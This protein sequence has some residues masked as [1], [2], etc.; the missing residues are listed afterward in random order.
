M[1]STKTVLIIISI[2]VLLMGVAG[3]V[4]NLNMGTEPQWHALLK[5]VIGAYGAYVGYGEKSTS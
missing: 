3:L 2:V 4:P 1:P 5:I